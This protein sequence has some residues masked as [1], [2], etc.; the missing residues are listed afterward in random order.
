MIYEQSA[1]SEF[2]QSRGGIGHLLRSFTEM[3]PAKLS[4][5]SGSLFRRFGDSFALLV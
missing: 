4:V 2:E 1:L 5:F 3:N